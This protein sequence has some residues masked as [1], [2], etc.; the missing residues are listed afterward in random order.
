MVM[1]TTSLKLH[2][3]LKIFAENSELHNKYIISKWVCLQNF[4]TEEM[5]RRIKIKFARLV[6]FQTTYTRKCA[7]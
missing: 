4:L 5:V 7:T 3:R 6:N 2:Y 1:R